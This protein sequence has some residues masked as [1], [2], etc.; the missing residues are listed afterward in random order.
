NVWFAEAA[1]GRFYMVQGNW[2]D[3]FLDQLSS[4][5]EGHDDRVDSVSGARH[6]VAPVR[7]WST[8]P[9]LSV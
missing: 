5:P 6:V 8:T 1:Q 9:F 7:M 3:G 2:N 4:F